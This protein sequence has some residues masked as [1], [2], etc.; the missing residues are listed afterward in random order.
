MRQLAQGS[1]VPH[2]LHPGPGAVLSHVLPRH[3]EVFVVFYFLDVLLKIM[4]T[5]EMFLQVLFPNRFQT[6]ANWIL[7]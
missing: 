7:P 4:A 5:M 1:R 2:S 3:M 6:A